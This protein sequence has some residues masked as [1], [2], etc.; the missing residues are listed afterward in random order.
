MLTEI[1]ELK[2]TVYVHRTACRT[3][4]AC[5]NLK[6]SGLACSVLSDDTDTRLQ[7]GSK[8][9]VTKHHI[10]SVIAV[11]DFVKLQYRWTQWLN[12]G[13]IKSHLALLFDRLQIRSVE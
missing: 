7:T 8:I 3:Q 1:S 2:I 13:K 11:G 10:G 5:D 4:C 12:F 9:H 6:E